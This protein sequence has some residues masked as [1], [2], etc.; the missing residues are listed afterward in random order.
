MFPNV[1][2]GN[3]RS[4][5]K[6]VVVIKINGQKV[7]SWIDFSVEINSL[8]AVDCFCVVLPWDVS[9]NPADMLLYSGSTDSSFLVN[10]SA[11]VR[12]EAG[13]YGE[14]CKLLIDGKMDTA[15]WSFDGDY[16][17]T[18]EIKGRSFAAAPFDFK[19]SVK[20]LNLTST[21]AHAQ[22]AR[23][24]GLNPVSPVKTNTMIGEFINDDHAAVTRETSHWDY[25]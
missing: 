11:S 21:D 25:V 8:G 12:I 20:F 9:D 19:E 6:P 22:M 17:E 5:G 18:V 23:L 3:F 13:F 7:V 4:F 15:R 24:H 1:N 14:E 10:G 2:Y 16:G